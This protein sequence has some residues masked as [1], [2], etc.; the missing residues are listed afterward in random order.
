MLKVFP[1]FT[2]I[3]VSPRRTWPADLS[4]NDLD[5]K[6]LVGHKQVTD[7]YLVALALSRQSVLATFD[8]GLAMLHPGAILV[9]TA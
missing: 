3:D 6:L 2:S 5:L 9:P 7:A 8:K 4:F 1:Y